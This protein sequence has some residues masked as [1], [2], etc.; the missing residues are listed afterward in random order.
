MLISGHAY[1]A[2]MLNLRLKNF[3]RK[4]P[5][6][7]LKKRDLIK[8]SNLKLNRNKDYRKHKLNRNALWKEWIYLTVSAIAIT[9]V[10]YFLIT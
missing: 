10:T 3:S 4:P 8:S 7:N 5:M 6:L 2:T 9:Y 1:H